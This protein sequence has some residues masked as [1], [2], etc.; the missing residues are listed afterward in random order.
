MVNVGGGAVVC[1][2][3]VVDVAVVVVVVVVCGQCRV[4]GVSI[5]CPCD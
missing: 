2:V 3:G 1:V 4:A 5:D